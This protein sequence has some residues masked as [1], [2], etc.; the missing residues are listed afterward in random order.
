MRSPPG[1]VMYHLNLGKLLR[2]RSLGL[3]ENIDRDLMLTVGWSLPCLEVFM[4]HQNFLPVKQHGW[5]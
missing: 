2:V 5:W 3:I 4:Q 1:D